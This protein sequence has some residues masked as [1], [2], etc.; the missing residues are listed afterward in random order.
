MTRRLCLAI[1]A[2]SLLLPASAAT[3]KP[4]PLHNDSVVSPAAAKASRST[5]VITSISPKH[6]VVGGTLTIKGKN[7]VP[8]AA[9]NRV[10]FYRVGGGSTWVKAEKASTTKIVVTIPDKLSKLLPTTGKEARVQLRVLA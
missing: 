2:S 10:F 8:G 9:K 6:A 7:F 1:T 4:A 5:P 3:A